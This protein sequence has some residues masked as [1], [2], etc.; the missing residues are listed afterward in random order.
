MPELS[1]DNIFGMRGKV[2]LVT[3]ATKG[4]GLAMVD[5]FAAAGASIVVSSNED[6]ACD[7]LEA[8]LREQGVEAAGIPCDVTCPHELESLVS[9]ALKRFGRVDTLVCNAGIQ[10]PFGPMH[11]ASERETDAVFQVNLFH[12][13]RL[14]SIVAPQMAERGSGSIILTS[15][16]AGL[17]GNKSVGLYAMTKAALSQLARN[18]AVEWGPRNVRANAIA[19][20][21]ISTEWASAIASSPEASNRRLGLTPLRRIG[22]PSEVAAAALFLASPGAGFITGQTLVVDGGTLVSDGN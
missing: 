10:G 20:G 12:P 14:S 17:R 8:R 19:P 11:T 21:L 3:G 15:S 2:V 4:I 13:L 22:T 16:I 9:A 5:A 6:D 7:A 1:L 18:L